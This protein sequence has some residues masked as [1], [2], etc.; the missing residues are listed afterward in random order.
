MKHILVLVMSLMLTV[1]AY[2]TE[3]V[4]LKELGKIEGWRENH[5]VG[6]GIVTGLAGTGDSS[7]SRAT[8]QSVAN[9]MS[10]YGV[11]V[12]S[13]QVR[14]RNVA[15]VSL[16]ALLPPVTHRGDK[17]DV[18]V[19]SMGD[20]RSLLG[21]T[22]LLASL[23]G[24]DGK[25]YALA[26]GSVSVGGYKFDQ[27][28]NVSQKNHPTAGVISGGA[29]AEKEVVA[30]PLRTD[31]SVNFIL[32]DPGYTNVERIS[33]AINKKL[34]GVYTKVKDSSSVHVLMPAKF[35]QDRSS[36]ISALESVEVV[37]DVKARVV[38]NEKTGIIVTGGNVKLSKT[39]VAHGDL[40]VSITNS[41]LV[42]QPQVIGR[43]GPNIRTQVVPNSRIRVKEA[44]SNMIELPES[45]SVSDLLKALR[46]I[47]ASTRDTISILQGIKAAGA[48]H[49]EL[50]LQ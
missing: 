40:R 39:T 32:N 50:I 5:L 21:G 29:Q 24:P 44:R 2:A 45:S 42:S 11:L 12:S 46:E 8:A 9:F 20:A 27:F 6:L 7:R 26:Q 4:R 13:S 3:T 31:G 28:G 17:L 49:A 10:N 43:A 34:S 22:L 1:T 41:F 38:I 16:M 19:T 25:V 48:L 18:T 35:N 15:I 36:F 33:A 14:S 47:K 30:S 37:P 23:K